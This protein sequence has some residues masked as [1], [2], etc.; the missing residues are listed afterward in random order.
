MAFVRRF[1]K[2]RSIRKFYAGFE[3]KF[4]FTVI[5]NAIKMVV[6]E[7]TKGKIKSGFRK[8]NF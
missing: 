8:I 6:Y 1:A 3:A 7:E 4:L 2:Q 5:F